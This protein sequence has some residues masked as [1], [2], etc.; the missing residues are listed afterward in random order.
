MSATAVS[1]K[2][3]VEAGFIYV[4][5]IRTSKEDGEKTRKIIEDI[6]DQ[7]IDFQYN[8]SVTNEKIVKIGIALTAGTF[9]GIYSINRESKGKGSDLTRIIGIGGAALIMCGAKQC[10]EINTAMNEQGQQLLNRINE[11]FQ[12]YNY[13]PLN[14]ILHSQAAYI[15]NL[16]LTSLEPELKERIRVITLGGMTQISE[17]ACDFVLNIQLNND[18]VPSIVGTSLNFF[19]NVMG[20]KEQRKISRIDNSDEN[21][22]VHAINTYLDQKEIKELLKILAQPDCYTII[23]K[24]NVLISSAF[25]ELKDRIQ[26]LQPNS[27]Q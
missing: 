17:D 1:Q 26:K 18:P 19:R 12:T 10:A 16:A 27:N 25:L 6:I 3:F 4:N 9:A 8:D 14:L 5:G 21:W 20:Y 13:S 23:S 11:F 15:G 24:N 22:T 2:I 7:K